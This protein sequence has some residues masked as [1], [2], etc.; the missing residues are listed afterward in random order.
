M[1]KPREAE[2]KLCT[3]NTPTSCL[4]SLVIVLA[5]TCLVDWMKA[6]PWSIGRCSM[7]KPVKGDEVTANDDFLL[8]PSDEILAEWRNHR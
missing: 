5:I 2:E 4:G 3:H 6:Y 8:K 7:L 1:L